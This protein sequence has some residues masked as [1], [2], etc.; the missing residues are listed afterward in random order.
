MQFVTIDQEAT[1]RVGVVRAN[2]EN[3]MNWRE[4]SN[5]IPEGFM[6][7][8]DPGC[9]A[10]YTVDLTEDGPF[11]HLSVSVL[12]N[13]GNFTEVPSFLLF[14]IAQLFGFTLDEDNLY[15]G[16][17]PETDDPRVMHILEPLELGEAAEA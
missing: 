11:K 17:D 14:I 13:D 8:F 5:E 7:Q 2:A 15:L 3:P 1:E 4:G 10:V 16:P 9:S 6:V 12:G